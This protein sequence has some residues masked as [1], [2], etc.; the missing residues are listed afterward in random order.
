ML[1][2]SNLDHYDLLFLDAQKRRIKQEENS[3]KRPKEYERKK[4]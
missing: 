3:L 2:E 4:N 1:K